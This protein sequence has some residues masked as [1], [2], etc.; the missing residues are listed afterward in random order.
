MEFTLYNMKFF[1]GPEKKKKLTFF[2]GKIDA[3]R[4]LSS[5]NLKIMLSSER[6]A[7]RIYRDVIFRGSE[8][9]SYGFK[10]FLLEN[11][12]LLVFG[13]VSNKKLIFPVCVVGIKPGKKVKLFEIEENFEA[14]ETILKQPERAEQTHLDKWSE[15]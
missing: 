7:K 12:D 5:G 1:L 13:I 8:L 15:T 4:S 14:Y 9:K 3:I 6:N 11:K 10:D 2:R